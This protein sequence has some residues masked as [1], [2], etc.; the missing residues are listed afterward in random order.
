MER[1]WSIVGSGWSKTKNKYASKNKHHV[2]SSEC[3]FDVESTDDG[4]VV[5]GNDKP[6][7]KLVKNSLN[8]NDSLALGI[9]NN[10]LGRSDRTFDESTSSN[11]SDDNCFQISKNDYEEIK[12]RVAAIESRISHE[13]GTIRKSIQHHSPIV[14]NS[15]KSS[16]RLSGPERV[17][18]QYERMVVETEALSSPATEQLAQRLSRG[19]KI[20]RSTDQRVIRSPSAR[21]IGTI[22]RR[23][24]D[25]MRLPRN[26]TLHAS[27]TNRDFVLNINSKCVKSIPQLTSVGD[28]AHPLLPNSFYSKGNL[29]RGKPNT[30]HTGLLPLSQ[31]QQDNSD[32]DLDGISNK[33]YLSEQWMSGEVF[34]NNFV[35]NSPL[36]KVKEISLNNR[37]VEHVKTPINRKI[38]FDDVKT[39]M[40]PPK[41][42]PRKAVT[43]KTPSHIAITATNELQI[44][45]RMAISTPIDED[46]SGRASIARLRTQNA[47][48][49]M[50]KAK[51]FDDLGTCSSERAPPRTELTQFSPQTRQKSARLSSSNRQLLK[52][53]MSSL[54]NSS[55]SINSCTS[56]EVT[57]KTTLKST[58]I[59]KRIQSTSVNSPTSSKRRQRLA[60]VK[61]SQKQIMHSIVADEELVKTRNSNSRP[62]NR[63]NE[64]RQT[65][66]ENFI[67]SP[68]TSKIAYIHYRSAKSPRRINKH[69]NPQHY[70]HSKFCTVTNSP[71]GNP[72]KKTPLHRPSPR[73]IASKYN[74]PFAL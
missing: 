9:A 65:S 21:K 74:K 66:R 4:D 63:E 56:A 25:N 72:S 62:L 57:P 13:F 33:E 54:E 38:K 69:S 53:N 47:G 12:D 40:L 61:Y 59:A 64:M 39:P 17:Q 71:S 51:L 41:S 35:V 28:T 14:V 16:G 32:V 11:G 15:T 70:Q 36:Q 27:S 19:L 42:L 45:N 23:S 10:S 18:T 52:P 73:N 3:I 20:R 29:K 58:P 46:A 43:V 49:V 67:S 30:L 2:Q 7:D 5:D 24:Q 26:S 60:A 55:V 37:H 8:Q 50:A 68:R 22:R 34:F 6:D 1:R 48:M 44:V 31:Q